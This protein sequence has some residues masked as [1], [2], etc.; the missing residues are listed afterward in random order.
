MVHKV[1]RL[2]EEEVFVVVFGFDDEF[3]GFFAD[4]LGYLIDARLKQAGRVG[5]GFGI[6]PPVLDDTL[7]VVQEV[8]TGIGLVETGIRSRMTGWSRRIHRYQKRILIAVHLYI[9][10][11]QEI[12][13]GF[14]LGPQPVFGAAVEGYFPLGLRFFYGLPIHVTQHKHLLG[15]GILNDGRNEAVSFV[16]VE[17]IDVHCLFF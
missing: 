9:L 11:V 15:A 14:A 16:E 8:L 17:L 4:L 12:A 5:A 13:R 10:Q 7:Q 3:H 6:I 2:V 1:G